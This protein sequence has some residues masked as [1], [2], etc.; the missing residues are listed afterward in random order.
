MI[1]SKKESFQILALNN[2]ELFKKLLTI[3]EDP[4]LRIQENQNFDHYHF[5]YAL[6]KRGIK[7]PF[8]ILGLHLLFYQPGVKPVKFA[9]NFVHLYDYIFYFV[10]GQMMV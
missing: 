4:R 3:K 8:L 5:S 9:S 7:P 10:K 2:L 6:H 1:K